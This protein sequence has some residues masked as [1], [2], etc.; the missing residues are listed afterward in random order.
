MIHM[1]VYILEANKA[2]N[3]LKPGE[4]TI[5]TVKRGINNLLTDILFMFRQSFSADIRRRSF[6]LSMAKVII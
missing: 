2:V 4:A 3:I 6:S 1:N 5:L